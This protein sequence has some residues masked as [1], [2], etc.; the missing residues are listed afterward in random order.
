[1]LVRNT[2]NRFSKPFLGVYSSSKSFSKQ[3]NEVANALIEEFKRFLPPK[4]KVTLQDS[5]KKKGYDFV[6][7]P[8][9]NNEQ[10]SLNAY[11]G[12]RIEG[13]G[14]DRYATYTKGENVHVGNYDKKSATYLKEDLQNK[15]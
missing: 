5:F 2:D 11:R 12:F 7:E 6:I 13:S 1:M 8:A 9:T 3:Q 14:V 4:N 15:L 10:V